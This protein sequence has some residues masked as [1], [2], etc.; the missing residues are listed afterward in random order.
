VAFG[1]AAGGGKSFLGCLWIVYSCLR[2]DGSR[3]LIGRS[4]LKA[5]KKTTLVT[6]FA[7]LKLF[8]LKIG[9]DVIYNQ[10]DGELLFTLNGSRI[11]LVDLK[12]YPSKDPEFDNLGS[13]EI[14]GAFID[15]ASQIIEKCKSIVGS[16]CRYKLDEFGL[17][18]KILYTCNP[19]KN[20]VYK[21]F[22][23]PN[24]EGSIQKQ[25]AFVQALA[26][27]NINVSIHYIKQLQRLVGASKER[28]YFG[29]WEY[30]DDPTRLFE[31]GHLQ[32]MFS[33]SVN[34]VHKKI[35]KYYISVDVARLGSDKTVI[36]VWY[37]LEVIK[38]IKMD[39]STVSQVCDRVHS[40]SAFY[41]IPRSRVIADEDGVGGGVVDMLKC[42]GFINGSSPKGQ[43]NYQNLKT[44]CYFMLK[45]LVEQGRIGIK[46]R[47]YM[48]DIIEEMSQIKEIDADKDGKIKIIKKSELIKTLGKSPDYADAIMMRMFYELGQN[49]NV[50]LSMVNSY[51]KAETVFGDIYN[52]Q[53]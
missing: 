20:W 43:T 14:T 1:G 38:I 12:Y 51:N 42:K 23:L 48:E 24:R 5:L 52:Q 19:T 50:S 16:R 3:W 45:A 30:D 46:P 47:D 8:Q 22:Y 29:N 25:R 36:C 33:N 7:V 13:L 53:F 28:L 39:K 40:L 41:N 15:E 34:E 26:R 6:L 21:Q 9:E 31:Y 10:Q 49:K 18:P 11:I 37:G 35:Y 44:Q 32:S 27:D 17:I 4:E 2:Y